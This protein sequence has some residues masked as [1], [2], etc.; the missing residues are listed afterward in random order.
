MWIRK[1]NTDNFK[2]RAILQMT[3]LI[4]V[5]ADSQSDLIND[6]KRAFMKDGGL[7]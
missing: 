4:G 5:N 6:K 7:L 2:F 3:K 1:L